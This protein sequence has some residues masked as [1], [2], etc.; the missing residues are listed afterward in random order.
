MRFKLLVERLSIKLL[1]VTE[2]AHFFFCHRDL[3]KMR[4]GEDEAWLSNDL[5]KTKRPYNETYL[6]RFVTPNMVGLGSMLI[7]TVAHVP[8]TLQRL[9]A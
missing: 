8:D 6:K 3:V 7:S 2:F 1:R 5:V 9:I 4:L